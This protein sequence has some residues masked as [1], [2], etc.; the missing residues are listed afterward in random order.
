MADIFISYSKKDRDK[1]Q[2]L[3]AFLEAEGWTVWWDAS[4]LTGEKF[5][6][7]IVE[8]LAAARVVIVIWTAY[9][10]TSDWVQSEAGRGQ[11]EHKLIPVKAPGLEYKDIPPPFD[12]MHTEA[13]N[14]L[15]HIKAAIMGLMAKAPPPP[16]I[17]NKCM[18]F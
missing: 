11:A 4:L 12:Q 8:E 2:L 7:K 5:R 17:W 1:A 6:K 15:A 16:P 3:S 10:V 18:S 13:L 9:S 14:N